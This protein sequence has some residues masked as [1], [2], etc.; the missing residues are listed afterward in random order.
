MPISS[1]KRSYSEGK[2]G[3]GVG[4]GGNFLYLDRHSGVNSNSTD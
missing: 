1:D 2:G 4:E 3:G